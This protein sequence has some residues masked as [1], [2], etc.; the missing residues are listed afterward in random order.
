MNTVVDTSPPWLLFGALFALALAGR[1]LILS[2]CALSGRWTRWALSALAATMPPVTHTNASTAM[3][4]PAAPIRSAV[5]GSFHR[6]STPS[7]T[8]ATV[9]CSADLHRPHASTGTYAPA[10]VLVHI[11]VK[12]KASI[13][14]ASVSTTERATFARAR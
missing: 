14:E 13:V 8:G 3:V 11:G 10:S 2:G 6:M 5:R 4:G 1:W 12:K 7:T 9:S